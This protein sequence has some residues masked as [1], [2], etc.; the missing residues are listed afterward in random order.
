[1]INRKIF[2]IAICH[3]EHSQPVDVI[4]ALGYPPSLELINERLKRLKAAA[5]LNQNGYKFITEHGRDVRI[6]QLTLAMVAPIVAMDSFTDVSDEDVITEAK[7]KL[8][9]QGRFEVYINKVPVPQ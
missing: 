4:A 2:V 1:M 7:A 6:N 3:A 5:D 9:S 8:T